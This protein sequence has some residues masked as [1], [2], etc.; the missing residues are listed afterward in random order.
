V[1]WCIVG[2]EADEFRANPE[3]VE[4]GLGNIAATILLLLGFEA[5]ADYLPPLVVPK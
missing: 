5:P 4:P 2:P 1:P 3:V